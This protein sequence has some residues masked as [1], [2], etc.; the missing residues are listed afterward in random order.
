[1]DE[2]KTNGLTESTVE[3]PVQSEGRAMLEQAFARGSGHI[4]DAPP[5]APERMEHSV[6]EGLPPAKAE[7]IAAMRRELADLQRQLIDAQQR[8]ATELQGRAEDAERF[9]VLEARLQAQDVKAQQAATRITEL[10]TEAASLRA[11]LTSVGATAEELRR[12]VASRDTQLEDA[13]KQHRDVTE[14]LEAQRSSLSETKALLETRD[15]ELAARTAE[16]ATRTADLATRTSERDSEQA[17]KSRLEQELEDLRKQHAEV[18]SQLDLQ[19]ASLRAANALIAKRDAELAAI[20]SE[21][22]ALKSDVAAGRAKVRE[23]ADQLARI[24]RDLIEGG[25]DAKPSSDSEPSPGVTTPS[26]ERL[27]PPPVPPLRAANSGPPKVETILEVT[28]EPRSSARVGL[29]LIA[30]LILGAVATFAVMKWTSA[31]STGDEG[32]AVGAS[33]SAALPS[34]RASEPALPAAQRE[35]AVDVSGTPSAQ[36][37]PSSDTDVSARPNDESASPSTAAVQSATDGVL[38]LPQEAADHRLFVDGRIV[39]VKNSRAVVPCGTR[40]IRI[41]SHGTPRTLDVACGAETT[42]PVG[43]ADR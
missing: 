39:P 20:T 33:Q 13:R 24:G 31:S 28:E 18:T 19:F 7:R 41:G 27:K 17:A 16:L 22:D 4:N 40:E 1:M 36:P 26:A 21:R 37:T 43:T 34:D 15:G 12:D 6:M 29:M 9:E 8:I 5:T 25:G 3:K 30:A 2:R 38:V 42:V 23:V 14:Q 32:Q 11:Q 10:E 35:P